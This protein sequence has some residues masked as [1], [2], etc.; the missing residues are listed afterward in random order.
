MKLSIAGAAF[1]AAL[2]ASTSAFAAGTTTLATT[3]AA[4]AKPMS[5]DSGARCTS[6][7][8]Q[9]KT[10]EGANATNASLGKAKADAAKGEKMCKSKKTSDKKKGA[11]D[12]EAALKLLGVTPS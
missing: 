3:T 7:A 6:L 12:Y 11:A 1:A 2:L 4:A 10:A 5:A 9:W 8:D